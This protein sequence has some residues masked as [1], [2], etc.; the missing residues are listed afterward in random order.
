MSLVLCPDP[1]SE[2]MVWWRL[3]DPSGFINVDHFLG[4]NFPTTNH[5]AENTICSATP[6]ISWLLQHDDTALFGMWTSYPLSTMDTASY[7]LLMKPQESAECHQTLS[8]QDLVWSGH[9]TNVSREWHMSLNTYWSY[10]LS[11]TFPGWQPSVPTSG[12]WQSIQ[13]KSHPM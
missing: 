9:E 12:S 4:E 10:G 1:T 13:S 2:E 6:E 11:T 8:S 3:A 7:E 5:I